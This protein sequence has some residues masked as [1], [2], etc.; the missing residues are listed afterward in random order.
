MNE[1][2]ISILKMLGFDDALDLLQRRVKKEKIDEEWFVAAE[3]PFRKQM[4]GRWDREE[5]PK[6]DNSRGE[7]QSSFENRLERVKK[8]DLP[9][10]NIYRSEKS[11]KRKKD[12]SP[13][14]QLRHRGSN[15]DTHKYTVRWK[16]QPQKRSKTEEGFATDTPLPKKE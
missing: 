9:S 15:L 12:R 2:D 14:K 11:R 5:P 7:D 13:K 8:E 6:S 1:N 4:T 16:D 10:S 3:S